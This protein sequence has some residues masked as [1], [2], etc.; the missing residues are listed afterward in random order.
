MARSQAHSLIQSAVA[1]IQNAAAIL[2]NSKFSESAIDKFR[3]RLAGVLGRVSGDVA[4]LAWQDGRGAG[5]PPADIARAYHA[6]QTH[7]L[8]GW[9]ADIAK[10]GRLVGGAGRAAMYGESLGQVYQRAYFLARG[11]RV[12]LPDLPAYPRDGSTVCLTHCRC[13]WKIVKRAGDLYEATWRLG[14]AEHCSDC[15]K[16]SQEWNPLRMMRIGEQWKLFTR[17]PQ[18]GLFEPARI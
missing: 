8:E 3:A 17:G 9:V 11:S 16:R 1:Q 4:A 15:L 14:Q 10:A 5:E 2:M 6:E 7:F 12:G 18:G 13:Q